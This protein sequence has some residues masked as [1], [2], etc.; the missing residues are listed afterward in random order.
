[1]DIGVLSMTLLL[2]DCLVKL[3]IICSYNALYFNIYISIYNIYIY[4]YVS[5]SIFV[6][7]IEEIFI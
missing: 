5:S 7:S 1:M 3:E 6:Y 4:N 2:V